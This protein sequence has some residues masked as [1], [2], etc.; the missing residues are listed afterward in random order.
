MEVVADSADLY[1]IPGVLEA[2]G[3]E[4]PST[5]D[6]NWIAKILKA[7]TAFRLCIDTVMIVFLS[8]NLLK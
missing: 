2:F 6:K 5:I 4:K 7:R 3:I 1:V 8:K